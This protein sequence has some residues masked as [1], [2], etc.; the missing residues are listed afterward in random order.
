MRRY[1][2]AYSGTATRTVEEID[3]SVLVARV[4]SKD[5]IVAFTHRSC[6]FVPK[7]SM[8]TTWEQIRKHGESCIRFIQ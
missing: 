1:L 7:G 5:E 3:E 6:Y 2:I 8:W 4:N